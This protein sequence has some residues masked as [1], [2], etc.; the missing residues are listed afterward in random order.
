MVQGLDIA[1][2]D[3]YT[4]ENWVQTWFELY[5]KPN[6]RP[7]TADYRRFIDCHIVP[8]LGSIKGGM[9]H[10]KGLEGRDEDLTS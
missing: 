2:S 4:V 5:S 1:R 7:T 10:P 9:H 3:D 6:I 8:N